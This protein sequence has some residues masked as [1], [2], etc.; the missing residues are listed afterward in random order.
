MTDLVPNIWQ[1]QA[2][3]DIPGLLAALEY[4]DPA[5]RRRAAAALRTLSAVSALEGLEK[6]MAVE[7]DP[8][9][10]ATIAAALEYLLVEQGPVRLSETR[11]LVEQ[12]RSDDLNNAIKAAQELAVLKDKTAVEAL[13]MIFHDSRQS[14]KLRLAAAEALVALESAPALVT[15]L[16]ALSSPE[17]AIRRNAAA[18]LGQLRAD[19]AV[20]PL[21]DRLQDSNDVVRRTC[22]AALKRIGTPEAL[23]AARG[24]TRPLQAPMPPP[25]PASQLPATKPLTSAH[26]D[27]TRPRPPKDWKKTSATD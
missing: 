24:D 17:W 18:V 14:S 9:V 12:L 8:S 7:D 23:A 5:I 26:T 27:E 20:Q 10:R 16:V 3:S 19:W 22:R 13:V 6:R 21:I 25:P 15:L 1:L 2:K 4:P 11:R